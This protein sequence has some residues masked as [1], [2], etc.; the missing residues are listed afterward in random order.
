MSIFKAL[1]FVLFRTDS[2]P[3]LFENQLQYFDDKMGLEK[4]EIKKLNE[5]LYNHLYKILDFVSIIK[6]NKDIMIE[7]ISYFEKVYKEYNRIYSIMN[8]INFQ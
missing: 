2:E 5:D 6:P 3:N 8:P 7:L 4:Y 1:F